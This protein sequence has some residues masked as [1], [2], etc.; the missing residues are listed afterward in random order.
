LDHFAPLLRRCPVT[1]VLPDIGG[2]KRAK[3]FAVHWREGSTRSRCP[4]SWRSAE[5]AVKSQAMR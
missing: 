2:T 1:V 3:E 4:P 5:A